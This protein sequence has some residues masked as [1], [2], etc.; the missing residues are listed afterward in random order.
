MT[1]VE[2]DGYTFVEC[3][4]YTFGFKNAIEAF[5]FDE[6]D[7]NNPHFH[8]VPMKAVDIVAEFQDEYLFIE[9]KEFHDLSAYDVSSATSEEDANLK[10]AQFIRLKNYLKYKYRDSFLFRYAETKVDKPIHYICLLNFDNSLNLMMRK[11]LAKELPI[12]KKSKR[13]KRIIAASCL[14]TSINSLPK[15]S[16]P[17]DILISKTI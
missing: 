3:D 16:I 2:C 9:L 14:V 1:S 11:F 8:G 5:K 10:N 13:W 15:L 17:W 6:K 4:G 7:P 12:G